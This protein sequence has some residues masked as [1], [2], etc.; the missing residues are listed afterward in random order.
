MHGEV[1]PAL[2]Q[3]GIDFLGEQAL[4]ASLGERPILD[5]V[6]AGANDGDRHAPLVPAVRG[7]QPA[8]RLLGLREGERRAARAEGEEDWR[9]HRAAPLREIGAAG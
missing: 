4:A 7:G 5:E 2:E 6:A 8:A 1:D 9:S 3:G